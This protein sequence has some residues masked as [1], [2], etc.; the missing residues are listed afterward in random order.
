MGLGP[1]HAM[2]PLLQK[3]QLSLDDIDHFEI[4]EAF[5]AQV[6]GCNKAWNSSQ[7]CQKVLG[8][9]EAMGEIPMEK[10]NPQGGAI[11]LG[12]PVGASGARLAIHCAK[13]LQTN[14]THRAIASLC[15]GGGQGG[16]MLIESKEA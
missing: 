14:K 2:T 15:I 3:H 10:L 5:A 16:A 8:L 1:I 6:L 12:H 4:N 9:K 13:M 11:A 7:Y